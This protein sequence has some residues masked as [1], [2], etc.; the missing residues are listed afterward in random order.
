MWAIADVSYYF[1]F[2][3]A[4]DVSADR[5][6]RQASPGYGVFEEQRSSVSIH[7]QT[8]ASMLSCRSPIAHAQLEPEHKC[9]VGANGFPPLSLHFIF[10]TGTI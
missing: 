5:E 4:P 10:S 8:L 3:L 1:C 2:I 6:S 9:Q 7:S